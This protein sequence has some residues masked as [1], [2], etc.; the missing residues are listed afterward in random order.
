MRSFLKD[1]RAFL[2][3]LC[4][5]TLNMERLSQNAVWNFTD[6][7]KKKKKKKAKKIKLW[8]GFQFPG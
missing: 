1:N 3:K 7:T 8:K 6:A 4:S 2:E 5:A